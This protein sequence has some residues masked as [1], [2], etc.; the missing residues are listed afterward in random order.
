MNTCGVERAPAFNCSLLKVRL[1]GL[2][3]LN[4]IS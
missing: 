2:K 1:N 4:A 3:Q